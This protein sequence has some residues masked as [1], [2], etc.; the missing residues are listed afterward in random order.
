MSQVTIDGQEYDT[1]NLSEEVKA[2]LASLQFVKNEIARLNA[3]M[4][5]YRTAETGYAQAL[6]T[7][8]D[9]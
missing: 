1:D 7:E 9:K 8:L 3:Q 5:V 6:K 2:Q 4:A